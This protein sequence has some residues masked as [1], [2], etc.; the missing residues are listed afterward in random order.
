MTYV[1]T[2]ERSTKELRDQW[3][4]DAERSGTHYQPQTRIVT[5][6]DDVAERDAA[7]RGLMEIAEEAMPS[8]YFQSDSRTQA[9]REILERTDAPSPTGI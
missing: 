8:S 9:A 1:R 3:Q 5:L 4:N 6:I 7:L 2:T